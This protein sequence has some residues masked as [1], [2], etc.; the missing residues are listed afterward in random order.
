MI[1][2]FGDKFTQALYEGGSPRA[3]R[4][5]KT[6][7]ERKLQML[8]SATEPADLRFPPGNRLEK[9]AGDRK[10]QWSI[11]INDQWRLCFRFENGNAFEV[12]VTDYH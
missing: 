3:F 1:K 2:S 8:D 5:F 9:L 4:A 6:Q 10:G 11:R 7:A 12:E